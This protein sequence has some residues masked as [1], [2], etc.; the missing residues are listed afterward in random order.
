LCT[1]EVVASFCAAGYK[2]RSDDFFS[3]QKK[4]SFLFS[5]MYPFLGN[6]IIKQDLLLTREEFLK[7]VK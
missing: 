4:D 2:K 5:C 6:K 7:Y 1:N 3:V